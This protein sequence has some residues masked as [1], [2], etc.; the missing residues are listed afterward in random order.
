MWERQKAE[1]SWQILTT[2]AIIA[3]QRGMKYPYSAAAGP[4]TEDVLRCSFAVEGDVRRVICADCGS[5][6]GRFAAGRY[7][8]A[9]S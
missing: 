5:S 3:S 9:D 2:A 6:G 7:G 8:I 1:C 4:R